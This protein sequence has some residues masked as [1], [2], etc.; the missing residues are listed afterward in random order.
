MRPQTLQLALIIGLVGFTG[1]KGEDGADGNSCTVA[2]SSDGETA[3]I[4][5]TDGTSFTVASGTNG[6]DGS[7]GVDG[8]DCTVSEDTDGTKTITCEDG[9]SVTVLDGTDGKSCT[10]QD[11]GN[12]TY[13][14]TC[15]DGTT[16]TV[17]EPSDSGQLSF[18]VN[19]FHGIDAID[20]EML[21][22]GMYHADPEITAAT[23]DAAGKVS[24]TFTV[25]SADG[26]PN[27]NLSP[28]SI[29]ANVAKLVPGAVVSPTVSTA[30]KWVPYIWRTETVSGSTPGSWPKPD[31]TIA[32]QAYK[33]SNGTL[34]N[35]GGGVYRY[36]FATNLSAITVNSN[37]ISYQRNLKHRVVVMLGGTAGPLGSKSFDFVPDGSTVTET[38]NVID[39]ASC[40]QCHGPN[41]SAHGTTGRT[42]FEACASCHVAGSTDAQGGESLE[43]R[44]MIHKIHAGAELPSSPG[45][46]GMVFDDPALAGD[47]RAD[48]GAMNSDG[49]RRPYSI[50]GYQN[51]RYS[52]E[53]AEFPA[54]IAN[55]TKCH[56]GTGGDADNWKTKPSIAACGSCHET[57]DFVTGANHGGDAQT[58][59]TTCTLCHRTTGTSLTNISVAH[60]FTVRDS[61]NVP[62]YEAV[63]TVNTPTRGYF[64]PGEAPLVTL[65]L[66]DP[67]THVAIDHTTVVEDPTAEGCYVSY[68]PSSFA[69][70]CNPK[71]GLFKTANLFVDGPR[72]HRVPVLTTAARSQVV[73]A[74][75]GPW[76]LSAVGTSLILKVDGGRDVIVFDPITGAD[77]AA[78]ATI[79]VAVPSSG[80]FVDK[81]VATADEVVAWLNADA[82]FK[83]R[84]I[85]AKDVAGKVTLRSRA[86]GTVSSLQLQASGLTTTM[87][88]GD[89][90]AH[91]P[92]GS[93]TGN[94]VSSRISAANND[95]KAAR[96][97]ANIT[98]QLDPI[99]DLKAGTYIASV[100]IADGGRID[101]NNYRTPTV[102]RTTF[103]VKTAT[104]EL[105]PAGNC[106]SCHQN[107]AGQGLV[108]D[109]ARHQKIL[110]DS[111]ID[112]CG[113]CHDYQPQ[114]ATGATF[115]GAVPISR[116]IHAVHNG[117][118]LFYPV[119]TVAHA[120]EPV[121][122]AWDI[123]FP[124]DIRNCESCHQQGSTSGSWAVQPD[125]LA[126]GGCHDSDAATAHLRLQTYD[127]TPADPWSGDEV[128]SCGTCHTP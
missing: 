33:E 109:P 110:N 100:E 8:N 30:N 99:D 119:T 31:G 25:D 115:T 102:A 69:V 127:P 63:L 95:P 62:E 90:T 123:K 81:T 88:A 10:V 26:T 64:I 11:N 40:E 75:T 60:D 49:V 80:F 35:L 50:W 111:A 86:L 47:Q 120:D 44:T 112:Q 105:P 16:M 27:L 73:S 9:T 98:Y 96:T 68:P 106:D 20:Q 46:D 56:T 126:C 42:T 18:T 97:T 21:D 116:R 107:A 13:T 87:F 122:R 78:T 72:D 89:V 58:D 7:D 4:T 28:S 82:K 114:N 77:S 36:D 104:V 22:A 76:D 101:A 128:E 91:L 74:T 66:K 94:N 55:C 54:N 15:E 93:T 124:Q 17:A 57:V 14:I 61:R 23:A 43:A 65:V 67:T 79:T 38:R 48:N 32:Y 103:Q 70:A 71:D 41:F 5:C 3:T 113:A 37:P 1:C 84:A 118:E 19:H 92:I 39:T 29:S 121:G 53:T 24:V 52:W 125:R 12:A 6:A 45:A 51:H 85:A 59:D 83:L 2:Q 108:F 34:T 117:S